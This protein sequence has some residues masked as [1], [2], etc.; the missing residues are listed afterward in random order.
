M[1][2]EI[3]TD[4]RLCDP[5]QRFKVEVFLQTLDI[6][7]MQLKS[8]FE[9]IA[10]IT[11]VFECITAKVL[12][13]EKMSDNQLLV[14][15]NR[16]VDAYSDDISPNLGAQLIRLKTCFAGELKNK[17]LIRDVTEML[18]CHSK[19][20]SSFSDIITA[21]VIFLTLPVSVASAERSFSKLKL[22][23]NYLRSTMS[24][25]RLSSLAILAIERVRAKIIDINYVIDQFAK[26]KARSVPL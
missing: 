18:M 9:S 14:L 22:I 13:D 4:Q 26:A 19:A 6:V 2:D 10:E 5:E 20:S 8:R 3:I 21:G 12:Q 7:L 23:K 11:C 16:L 17:N 1:S 15:A 24:Q 25:H